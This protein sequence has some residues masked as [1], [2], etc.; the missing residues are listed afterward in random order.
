[1]LLTLDHTPEFTLPGM[2][3]D[4]H[5]PARADAPIACDMST[6][7]DTPD[8]RLAEY[9][10][11]F[12]RALVRRERPEQAVVFA[13]RATPDTREQVEDLAR[14]EAACCP[15]LDYRV[16]TTDDEV[17]YTV[18]NPMTGMERADAE[19]TL[20]AFYALPDHAGS[21]YAGLLERFADGGVRVGEAGSNRWELRDSTAG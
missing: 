18:T 4:L 16:Q 19:V 21:D 3:T 11:L 1:M 12:E 17:I 14:R 10:A 2:T 20:D 9:S 6:A 5:L 8:Q 13:F 7:A 15:F